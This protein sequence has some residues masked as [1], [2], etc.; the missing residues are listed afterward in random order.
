MSPAADSPVA[1]A[2]TAAN[3]VFDSQQ[4]HAPTQQVIGQSVICNAKI[5]TNTCCIMLSL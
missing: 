5:K 3:F 1:L 4:L 2:G